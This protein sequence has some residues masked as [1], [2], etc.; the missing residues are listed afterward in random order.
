MPPLCWLGWSR[1]T[2]TGRPGTREALSRT[3]VTECH[4]IDV[5]VT[6]KAAQCRVMG[7][8]ACCHDTLGIG[9]G[10]CRDSL[11]WVEADSAAADSA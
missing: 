10:M 8:A 4:S 9:C 11:E 1:V 3:A 5:R 7:R 2:S 6:E